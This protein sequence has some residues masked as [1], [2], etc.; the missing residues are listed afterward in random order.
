MITMEKVHCSNCIFLQIKIYRNPIDTILI[1]IGF[2]TKHNPNYPFGIML[3]MGNEITCPYKLGVPTELK[4]KKE[5]IE[6]L[7]KNTYI[8]PM[9][10]KI[11]PSLVQ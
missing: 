7:N 2:F 5:C 3:D 1:N 6:W 8:E 11:F 4:T 10:R 9:Q